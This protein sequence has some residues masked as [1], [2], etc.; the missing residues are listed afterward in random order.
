MIVYAFFTGVFRQL[1]LNVI[2]DMIRFKYTI[3]QFSICSSCSLFPFISLFLS[4][5]VLVFLVVHFISSLG[6]SA[7]TFC[8]C[9]H[10]AYWCYCC[11]HCCSKVYNIHLQLIQSIFEHCTTSPIVRDFT[12]ICGSYML[13][14]Y[15]Y[16]S[17]TLYVPSLLLPLN[18]VHFKP[19]SALSLTLL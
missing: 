13:Y 6:L 11:F 2:I 1:K 5:L 17:Y 3:L 4:C 8:F 12:T 19:H 14:V 18:I 10:L 7:I 15:M 16:T 9:F